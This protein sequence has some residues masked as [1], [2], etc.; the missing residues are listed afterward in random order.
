[1]KAV[2]TRQSAESEIATNT[3][4]DIFKYKFEIKSPRSAPTINPFENIDMETVEKNQSVEAVKT[5]S[6]TPSPSW[7]STLGPTSLST[8]SPTSWETSRR[9]M[10]RWLQVTSSKSSTIDNPQHLPHYHH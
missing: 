1:V 5:G 10:T 2:K 6:R 4:T 7:L 8:G 3:W 9:I